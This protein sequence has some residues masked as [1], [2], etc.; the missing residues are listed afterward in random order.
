MC[1]QKQSL[2]RLFLNLR[3][4]EITNIGRASHCCSE[5]GSFRYKFTWIS[6]TYKLLQ[7]DK[8]V[9][10]AVERGHVWACWCL[11]ADCKS[12]MKGLW[13]KRGKGY[14][15]HNWPV[16][17]S[18]VV[19][20]NCHLIIFLSFFENIEFL[21]RIH[22]PPICV[23]S[24]GMAVLYQALCEFWGRTIISKREKIFWYPLTQLLSLWPTYALSQSGNV[25][26]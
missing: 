26:L 15:L 21:N 14:V 13:K 8:L 23:L 22:V 12:V 18:S 9:W 7:P 17:S 1:I 16:P 24:N 5:T 2:R 11:Q 25:G 20:D 3:V 4:L 6:H 10:H 19:Q